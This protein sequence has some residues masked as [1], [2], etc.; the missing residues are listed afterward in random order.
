M[1]NTRRDYHQRRA[2]ILASGELQGKRQTRDH[3]LRLSARAT[4]SDRERQATGQYKQSLTDLLRYQA[5]ALPWTED[6]R[7]P[8]EPTDLPA[9]GGRH[10]PEAAMALPVAAAV[11]QRYF[12]ALTAR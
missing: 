12:H 6:H 4:L 2:E 3:R 1:P 8:L 11:D 9:T 5:D 10:T 7:W